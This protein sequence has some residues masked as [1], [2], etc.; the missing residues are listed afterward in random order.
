MMKK[1]LCICI[2]LI[3]LTFS[4]AAQV[5]KGYFYMATPPVYLYFLEGW[6]IR[7]L[8]QTKEGTDEFSNDVKYKLKRRNGIDFIRI[9][10]K[11]TDNAHDI[12]ENG[13]K[14]YA[15]L[16]TQF[17]CMFINKNGTLQAE[18]RNSQWL[19]EG[20]FTS[21][22]WF[23]TV[24]ATNEV[25]EGNT[26]YS[27][28]NIFD[29]KNFTSCFAMA[30]NGIGEKVVFDNTQK[31][32]QDNSAFNTDTDFEMLILISG[33]V[34]PGKPQLYTENSRPKKIKFT[35]HNPVL[36]KNTIKIVEVQDSPQPQIIEFDQLLLG[37]VITME[38]LEVY[39]GTKYS[40][41]C[42]SKLWEFHN[43]RSILENKT[44][45]TDEGFPNASWN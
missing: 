44:M 14:E 8:D 7:L 35:I 9:Y 34:H 6:N 37:K 22:K 39:P 3:L 10:G 24:H 11:L 5:P 36:K 19:S 25:R 20:T 2:G 40:D 45:F 29:G 1:F 18:Y 16:Y 42:I 31:K 32:Q 27:V 12:F 26:K 13:K 17:F 41:V 4:V 23:D 38:I 28:E 33:F 21:E 15:L 30:N 43:R